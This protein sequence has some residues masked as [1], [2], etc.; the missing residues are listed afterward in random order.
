MVYYEHRVV[1]LML[2]EL[3][4]MFSFYSGGGDVFQEEE[5][6]SGDIGSRRSLISSFASS[7]KSKQTNE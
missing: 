1:L 4:K 7:I 6:H 2:L 3:R 5:F